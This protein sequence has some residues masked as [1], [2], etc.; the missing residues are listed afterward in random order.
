[1][2]IARPMC[3][4]Q[5]LF[6]SRLLW[7]KTI[8]ATKAPRLSRFLLKGMARFWEQPCL[9]WAR[10]STRFTARTALF[11]RW[12]GSFSLT[13]ATHFWRSKSFQIWKENAKRYLWSL[14]TLCNQTL[15]FPLQR[16]NPTFPGAGLNC[17]S[18]EAQGMKKLM[19]LRWRKARGTLSPTPSIGHQASSLWRNLHAGIIQLATL[20][21][22]SLSL[23]WP[24]SEAA[25]ASAVF[26]ILPLLLS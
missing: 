19:R 10:W 2:E 24:Q 6:Y 21:F 13:S 20:V 23:A 16:W 9:T 12:L 18:L 25:A 3:I 4:F 1:M 17:Q 8:K 26:T 5:R 14:F 7:R 15:K 11:Q 22:P